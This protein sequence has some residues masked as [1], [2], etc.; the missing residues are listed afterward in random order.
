M[1]DW[2]VQVTDL[3]LAIYL[4]ITISELQTTWDVIKMLPLR[5]H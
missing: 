1:Q 3:P 5:S 4:N 2:W